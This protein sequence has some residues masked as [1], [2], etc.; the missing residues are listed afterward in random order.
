VQLGKL[1]NAD[2]VIT[3]TVR[4]YGEV[5][6][7]GSTGNLVALSLDLLEA[8]TGKVVWSAS[9]SRGGIS[10]ADRFFGGGGEPMNKVTEKVVRDLLDKLFR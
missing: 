6:S 2:A 8:E 4:E 10:A 3:G 9:S 5:R 7:G 1:V